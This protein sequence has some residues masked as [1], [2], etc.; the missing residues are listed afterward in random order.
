VFTKAIGD[1]VARGERVG[2]IKFGSRTDVIFAAGAQMRVRM[3]DTVKGGAT[4]LAVAQP[5]GSR[6]P[7][8]EMA[9]AQ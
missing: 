7:Q 6:Q 8:H 5:T 1:R 9:E 3:G 2:L 4:V